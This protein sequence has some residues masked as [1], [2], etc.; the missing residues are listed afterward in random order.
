[1]DRD[2]ENSLMIEGKTPSAGAPVPRRFDMA[3]SLATFVIQTDDWSG[4]L[5][6]ALTHSPLAHSLVDDDDRLEEC[7]KELNKILRAA[8]PERPPPPERSLL[9]NLEVLAVRRAF[10]SRLEHAPWFMLGVGRADPECRARYRL[11]RKRAVLVLN[12]WAQRVGRVFI[13][14][15]IG[16]L[17]ALFIARREHAAFDGELE[18]LRGLK[19]RLDHICAYD[20]PL[21]EEDPRRIAA[22]VS[23]GGL[24]KLLEDD[25]AKESSRIFRD[26]GLVFDGLERRWTLQGLYDAVKL[27]PSIE[28]GER[29]AFEAVIRAAADRVPGLV[30]GALRRAS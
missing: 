9:D 4:E 13:A 25:E 21:G 11:Y 15:T 17:R 5:S 24:F 30:R 29:G 3:S 19:A 23:L 28:I 16:D 12:R 1:M 26:L 22:R 18:A 6:D 2:L 14:E 27:A 10:P 7:L 8:L 20:A